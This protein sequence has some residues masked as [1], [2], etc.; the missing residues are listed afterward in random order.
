MSDPLFD[1]VPTLADPHGITDAELVD[2]QVAVSDDHD[3]AEGRGLPVVRA[4]GDAGAGWGLVPQG[5][6][7]LARTLA[8]VVAW[9]AGWTQETS[10]AGLLPVGIGTTF[11]QTFVEATSYG[12]AWDH[13]HADDH[14]HAGPSHTHD[15]QSHTH[16]VGSHHHFMAAHS[17]NLSAHTHSL[18]TG[19]SSFLAAASASNNPAGATNVSADT[20]T[21]SGTSGTA[22]PNVSNDS[23]GADTNDSSAFA[24]GA[25][26]NNTTTASGTANTAAKSASGSTASTNATT[27]LPPMRGVVYARKV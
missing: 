14:V 20:H 15:M 7:V 6:I 26:S 18:G 27:W 22:S 5:A 13:L 25:P 16:Q 9:G 11:S 2:G 8:E 19:G 4:I 3:H 17:H 21:H 1:G 10:L 24:S 12:T 23:T